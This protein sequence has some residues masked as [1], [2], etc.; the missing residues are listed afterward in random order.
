MRSFSILE[1][2]DFMGE[3]G[4]ND[5]LSKLEAKVFIV[6]DDQETANIWAYSLRQKRL[7]VIVT[8]TAEEAIQ[9]WVETIP[10]LIVID[11]NT[12]K[13]DGTGLCRILRGETVIP[14]L[15]LS[16]R[17]NESHILEI[18]QAGAD[19]CVAKPISPALFIAKVTAWLR[20]SWTMPTEALDVVKVGELTLDPTTRRV[21]T[22]SGDP[23]RLTN[24]E[25][26]LL[27]LLMSHPG[28]VFETE[29]II[30]RVWGFHGNGNNTLLKNV[31][32]RLRRKIDPDPD[33]PRYIYT[34]AG[35]GYKFLMN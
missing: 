35:L 5:R 26:R 27:H 31:V 32:Y 25:F 10:D 9:K 2:S 18:Y 4:F 14:I 20:R 33:Q 6:S 3:N 21:L 11:I 17:N 23:I 28:W 16:P 1:R 15:L 34:E 13:L 19:E 12:P 8:A 30:Q 24:L 22:K 7:E 29:D